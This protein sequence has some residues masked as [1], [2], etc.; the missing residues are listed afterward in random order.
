VSQEKCD[1]EGCSAKGTFTFQEGHVEAQLSTEN[2]AP[3]QLTSGTYCIPC[4]DK[5]SPAVC[6]TDGC[7]NRAAF[8]P[9]GSRW[10][11]AWYCV[12]CMIAFKKKLQKD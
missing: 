11:V 9:P 5:V 8:C 10:A 7:A 1:R 12:P 6:R 2:G 3:Y 4:I